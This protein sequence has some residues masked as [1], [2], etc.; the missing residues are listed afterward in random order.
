MLMTDDWNLSP[1]GEMNDDAFTIEMKAD[2]DGYLI[3]WAKAGVSGTLGPFN[4]LEIAERAM[5]AKRVELT[6]NDK[7]I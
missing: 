1:G 4:D 7:P 3:E 6:V 2:A 5:E